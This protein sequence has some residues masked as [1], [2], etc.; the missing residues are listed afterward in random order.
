M[1]DRVLT[2]TM[3]V[4]HNVLTKTLNCHIVEMEFQFIIE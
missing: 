4:K 3:Y 2:S 1:I